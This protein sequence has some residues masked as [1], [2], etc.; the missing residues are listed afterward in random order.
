[1]VNGVIDGLQL[2]AAAH[3]REHAIEVELPLLARMAPHAK[4]VGIAIS[5]VSVAA[6]TRWN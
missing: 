6:E 4:V 3:A 2:D 5:G 1:M